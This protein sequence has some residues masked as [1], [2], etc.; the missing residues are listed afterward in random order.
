MHTSLYTPPLTAAAKESQADFEAAQR[1]QRFTDALE[2]VSR[3]TLPS[4]QIKPSPDATWTPP[5]SVATLVGILN[6]AAKFGPIEEGAAFKILQDELTRAQAAET[7]QA[8]QR[9]QPGFRY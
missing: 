8:R 7:F 4:A 2:R 9:I 1:T 5:R 6:E 3:A